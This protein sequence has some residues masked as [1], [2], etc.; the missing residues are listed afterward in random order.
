MD[1]SRKRFARSNHFFPL[2]LPAMKRTV[3]T[4]V[5]DLLR[6]RKASSAHSSYWCGL[7]ASACAYNNGER[8]LQFILLWDLW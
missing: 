3:V 5:T 2:L 1:L 7:R 8:I 6:A 4:H